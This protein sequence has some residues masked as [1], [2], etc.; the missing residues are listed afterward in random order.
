MTAQVVLLLFVV[1]IIKHFAMDFLFQGPYQYKNKGTYGHPGGLMHAGIQAL[2]TFFLLIIFVPVLSYLLYVVALVEFVVH[3]HV[4]WAKMNINRVMG[5]KAD[6]HN[7]F[8]LLLG[9]DQLLH[10]LTYAW[11]VFVLL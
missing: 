8:W 1:F 7:E 9:F 6:T 3:Y 11:I 10:Y 5:W 4:D 2:S